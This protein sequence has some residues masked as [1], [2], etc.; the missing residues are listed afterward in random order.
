MVVIL[1]FI[2]QLTNSKVFSQSTTLTLD[3]KNVSIE[4][5]LNT[6]EAKTSYRFLYNKQLID[7]NRKVTINEKDQN[8]DQILSQLFSGTDV[9][10]VISGKQIVLSKENE[11][12]S[13][14]Q[15]STKITGRVTDYGGQPLPG[16]SVVVKGTTNGTITDSDGKYSL[17]NVVANAILKFSFMGMKG[18][19]ITISGKSTINVIL[20]DETIGLDEVVAIGYGSMKKSDI[21]GSVA[22]VNAKSLKEISSANITQSLQGRIAGVQI[23]TTSTRPGQEGQIRIRGTRSLTAS[24]EPLIVVDGIPFN[25]SLN[26]IS[27]SSIKSIDILKDVSSTAIYGSRGANGVI[28]ITMERSNTEIAKITYEGYEGIDVVA[29]KYSLYNGPEYL[30]MA[31]LADYDGYT[32]LEKQSIED[33]KFTDWQDL[34]YKHGRISDHQLNIAGGTKTGNYS[35][36][37]GYH[38]KTSV[39]PGIEFQ[40]YSLHTT[41]DQNIGNRIKVGLS[42]NISYSINDG[43][44]TNVMY[45]LLSIKPVDQAYDSTGAILVHPDGTPTS[46]NPLLYKNEENWTEHRERISTFNSL[47]GELEITKD[48]KYRIN[49]GANYSHDQYGNFYSSVIN[50]GGPATA[51][52]NNETSSDYTIENL[53]YYN[54]TF[55]QKHKLN[56]TGLYSIQKSN[57]NNTDAFATDMVA[58]YVKYY[59]LGLSNSNVNVPAGNQIYSKRVI[60]SYMARINYNYN[61]RYLITLTGR[62]DG[63]SVL[64]SGNKWHYYPAVA[65]AWAAINESFFKNQNTLSN[66][67]IRLSF[68]QTSNQAVEPYTTLGSISQNL[69]N[70]GSDNVYGYYLSTVSNEKLNWEYTKSSNIG[71]DFGFLKNRISGSVDFYHQHTSDILLKQKLPPTSGVSGPF[72]TNVGETQN[73]GMEISFTT[74]NFNKKFGWTSDFSFS[75]N[76]NKILALNSGV[77]RDEGNGWFVGHPMDVIY[78]YN[79]I[80]IW[81]LGEE[82]EAAKYGLEPGEIKVEDVNKNDQIDNGDKKI[83]GNLDPKFELGITNRFSY[84]GFDLSVVAFARVGGKLI[85]AIHQPQ[86]YLNMLGGAGARNGIKVNYWTSENSTNDYP[87]PN[88]SRGDNPQYGSTLGYFDASFLN[89][90]SINLGYTLSELR[91]LKAIRIYASCENVATFFSPYLKAGGITPQ[92]TGYGENGVSDSNSIPDRQLTIGANVPPARSFILGLSFNF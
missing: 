75:L 55:N 29:K 62:A 76:R 58:D 67:K 72:L 86:S 61:D 1:F 70:F 84:K 43:E 17:S 26:D 25:G 3:L 31:E 30:R 22:S 80:G 21:T 27:S 85:S 45:G 87:K 32:P 9:D 16:V 68:G 59:N 2:V 44:T 50:G 90:R 51:E 7:A 37:V 78:D 14:Q 35:F 36:G 15:L 79:K 81:Q 19:E 6:I 48:L 33:G 12:K 88:G 42:S 20:V 54:K 39:M 82:V 92:A 91:Q 10:Y 40:R 64:A 69:Y 89:L 57:Y 66:L 53:I 74:I 13:S 63:S 56:F 77:Q 46:T 65:L 83:L 71:I 11:K 23:Q 73:N 49:I 47:Y 28:L 34:M 38:N 24:N 4:E 18:Q 5:V 52:V 8:V 60:L 41:I